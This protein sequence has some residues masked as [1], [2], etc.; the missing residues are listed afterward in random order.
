MVTVTNSN[1]T[2]AV[3]MIGWFT[4][5]SNNLKLWIRAAQHPG[6]TLS[7]HHDAKL[8]IRSRGSIAA[9][10]QILPQSYFTACVYLFMPYVMLCVLSKKSA[11]HLKFARN[12]TDTPQ[13][14]WEKGLWRSQAPK[15]CHENC[16]G[17]T[18]LPMLESG[19]NATPRVP[20]RWLDSD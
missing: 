2:D 14:H 9:V 1:G 18:L 7:L 6:G 19:L 16:R 4:F 20:V 15:L 8:S 5:G 3:L 17:E 10:N 11:V 13:C 12:H